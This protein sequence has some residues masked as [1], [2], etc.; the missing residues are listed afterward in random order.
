MNYNRK[1]HKLLK[2]LTRLHSNRD[3]NKTKFYCNEVSLTFDKIDK[4]LNVSKKEREMILSDLWKSNE[5]LLC[6]IPENTEGCFINDPIGISSLSNKKYINKIIF[7]ILKYLGF[8][9]GTIYFLITIYDFIC[10]DK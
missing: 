3:K 7:K 10:K 9:S 8:I 5:I 4:F 2:E 6:Q 1:R